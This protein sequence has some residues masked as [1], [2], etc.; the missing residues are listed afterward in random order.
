MPPYVS[1]MLSKNALLK[2][3]DVVVKGWVTH[4]IGLK[5]PTEIDT[6]S[7]VL[8]TPAYLAIIG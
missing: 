3:G 8:I 1:E 4:L 2:N 6:A 5:L 7:M